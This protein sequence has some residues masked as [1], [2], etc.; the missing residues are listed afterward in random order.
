MYENPGHTR[1]QREQQWLDIR[2][3]FSDRVVDW[4]GLEEEEAH[5]WHKQLHIFEVPF[6]YIEYGIA[7][8]GALQLWLNSQK[9][10]G[11]TVSQY[12]QALRFGGAKSIKELFSA[13]GLRFDFS[14]STMGPLVDAVETEMRNI[15]AI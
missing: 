14:E 7:Q 2:S 13:A 9:D 11:R 8:L 15:N 3:R 12:K 6:Y 5:L 1:A 10:Y 4:T